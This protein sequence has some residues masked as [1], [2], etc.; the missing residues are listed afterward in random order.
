MGFDRW[1][2]ILPSLYRF[3]AELRKEKAKNAGPGIHARGAP[4]ASGRPSC[5]LGL[6]PGGQAQVSGISPVSVNL[7]MIIDSPRNS[8]VRRTFRSIEAADIV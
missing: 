1:R 8:G 6:S 2:P 3:G 7:S 4:A 5:Y